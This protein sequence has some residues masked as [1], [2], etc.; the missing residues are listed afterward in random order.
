MSTV[1]NTKWTGGMSFDANVNGHH[2]IMDIAKDSGGT[3]AGPRPKAML[4]AALAGCAGMDIV[5]ILE[6][7][8][9]EGYALDIAAEADSTTEHPIIYHTITVK[10]QFTGDN[11]P[12]EK[13]KK[14]VNLSTERYCGVSAML[15]KAANIIPK[16][17]LNDTEV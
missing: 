12:P 17:Y 2:I 7:M 3:D 8:K 1:V 10:F 9:V 15:N 14:A 11:L 13:L 6:K 4:L 5:S 16:I